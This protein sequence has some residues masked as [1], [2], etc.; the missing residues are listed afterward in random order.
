MTNGGLGVPADESGITTM[1]RRALLIGL[2]PMMTQGLVFFISDPA[3]GSR[4][5]QYMSP[6]FMFKAIAYSG[7][8]IFHLGIECFVLFHLQGAL[9]KG[10][11]TFFEFPLDNSGNELAALAIRDNRS[12]PGQYGIRYGNQYF[13][14]LSLSRY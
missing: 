1:V 3:V 6:R 2:A 13:L 11:L 12:Q 7:V 8:P 5:T 14:H 4:L 9:K 10:T